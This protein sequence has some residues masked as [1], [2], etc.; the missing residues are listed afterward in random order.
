MPGLKQIHRQTFGKL[1]ALW[2]KQ[3]SSTVA[4]DTIKNV[5]GVY[6]KTPTVTRWNST[7]DACNQIKILIAAS[8]DGMDKF[9]SIC[10]SLALPRFK[11]NEVLFLKE[12]VDVS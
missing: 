8:P 10:D 4:S 7:F 12:Y 1:Q 2:N 3:N 5:F 9:D 11:R 6:L